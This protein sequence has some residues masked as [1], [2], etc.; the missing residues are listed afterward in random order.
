MELSDYGQGKGNNRRVWR[1]KPCLSQRSVLECSHLS[2][3]TQSLQEFIRIVFYY[4][5]KGYEPE[6]THRELTENVA[7]GGAQISQTSVYCLY[8]IA[9]DRISKHA[10]QSV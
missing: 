6:L 4:F 9:R 1:C 8:V 7:E 3:M 10:I 5:C 2:K